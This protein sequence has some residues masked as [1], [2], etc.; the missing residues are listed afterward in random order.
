MI[1]HHNLLKVVLLLFLF[2]DKDA[3]DQR[4]WGKLATVTSL[5]NGRGGVL[6]T[7]ELFSR[8]QPSLTML[9]RILHI[10]GS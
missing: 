10:Q 2:P 6:D 3:E 4:T 5:E 8:T 9:Q 1:N 7:K